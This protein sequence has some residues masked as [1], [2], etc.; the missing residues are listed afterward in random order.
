MIRDEWTAG[1]E[2]MTEDGQKGFLKYYVRVTETDTTPVYGLKSEKY[3][4]DGLLEETESTPP[5]TASYAE[6]AGWA[7]RFA[8]NT[9]T[10]FSLLEMADEWIN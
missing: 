6:A 3:T 8:A 2:I 5:L 10:P 4:A 9:V 1:A 7:V